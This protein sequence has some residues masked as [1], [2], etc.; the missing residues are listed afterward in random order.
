[1]EQL[2]DNGNADIENGTW[3]VNMKEDGSGSKR[4]T[5]KA[6]SEMGAIIEAEDKFGGTAVSARLQGE[7][8]QGCTKGCTG[9]MCRDA[10]NCDANGRG[11]A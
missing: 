8:P 3:L 2:P 5:V 9:R 7:R 4:V 1:M 10:L 6:L 11:R